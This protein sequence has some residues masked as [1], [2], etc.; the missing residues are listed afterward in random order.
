MLNTISLGGKWIDSRLLTMFANVTE[1][2][3]ALHYLKES[4]LSPNH[5]N[6]IL[7]YCLLLCLGTYDLYP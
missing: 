7:V 4:N 3:A 2:Y 6:I 1:F 5:V